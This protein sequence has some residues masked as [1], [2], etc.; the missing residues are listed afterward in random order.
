M[1]KNV[2]GRD[3][4]LPAP[5]GFP[6]ALGR[7]NELPAPGGFPN[8]GGLAKG[9]EGT[10][11]GT[12]TDVGIGVDTG[13]CGSC[14]AGI[15]LVAGDCICVGVGVPIEVVPKLP[16]PLVTPIFG[17]AI[18]PG[19]FTPLTCCCGTCGNGVDIGGFT[20]S[21]C[22]LL[23]CGVVVGVAADCEVVVSCSGLIPGV[24]G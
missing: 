15:T 10:G 20:G 14:I 6:N 21:D 11:N 8:S 9:A 22:K 3:N 19:I 17:V 13:F 1:D 18:G 23:I 12:G 2:G 7:D 16:T 5:G 4:E 24:A